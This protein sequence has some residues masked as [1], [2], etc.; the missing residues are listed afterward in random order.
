MIFLI[1]FNSIIE[2]IKL[3]KVTHRYTIKIATKGA[4]PVINTPFADDFNLVT[5]N[6]SMHQALLKDIEEK[7][8]ST[9]LVIKPKNCCSL[10]ILGGK[11]TNI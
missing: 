6:K 4:L 3:Y 5:H 2:Y 7:I 8:K 11:T 10:S 9:G 1:V